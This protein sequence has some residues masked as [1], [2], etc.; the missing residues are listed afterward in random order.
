MLW[1]TSIVNSNSPTWAEG[2]SKGYFRGKGKLLP[3]WG[4]YKGSLIDYDN[5]EAVE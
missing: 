2:K 3:W 1:V 4:P 5:P